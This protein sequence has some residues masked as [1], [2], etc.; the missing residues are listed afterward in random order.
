MYE[1]LYH[2]GSGIYDSTLC[3]FYDPLHDQRGIE[4]MTPP[5]KGVESTTSNISAAPLGK[6]N[7]C[8]LP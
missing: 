8:P 4:S 2:I 3:G 6:T 7:D 5:L 1:P